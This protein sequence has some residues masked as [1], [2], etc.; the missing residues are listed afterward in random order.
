M[1]H[2]LLVNLKLKLRKTKRLLKINVSLS[3]D[4]DFFG[5]SMVI[6]S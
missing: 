6:R 4:A 5:N 1:S 3:I 2:C